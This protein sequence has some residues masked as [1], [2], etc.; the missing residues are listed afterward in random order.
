MRIKQTWNLVDAQ[1]W[2]TLLIAHPVGLLARLISVHKRLFSDIILNPWSVDQW[3]LWMQFEQLRGLRS[4]P[5]GR[6]EPGRHCQCSSSSGENTF[7]LL[8]S[9]NL[10]FLVKILAHSFAHT[11]VP[12]DFLYWSSK[13][14][15]LIFF[16]GF[17]CLSQKIP[18]SLVRHSSI[19][20]RALNG[21]P[22]VSH[23]IWHSLLG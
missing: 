2:L 15:R 3:S 1:R 8:V 9:W 16:K 5:Q 20:I 7:S 19:I 10:R 21:T 18:Q 23:K 12:L 13:P 4:R 6:T 22:S 11:A 14:L 17:I